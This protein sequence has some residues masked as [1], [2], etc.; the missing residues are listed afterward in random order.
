MDKKLKWMAPQTDRQMD[1]KSNL[2]ASSKLAVYVLLILFISSCERV[3]TV[4]IDILIISRNS[5]K[6]IMQLIKITHKSPKESI[7]IF[8]SKIYL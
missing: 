3:E 2:D 5:K 1:P 4:D 6:K 8:Q 7:Q